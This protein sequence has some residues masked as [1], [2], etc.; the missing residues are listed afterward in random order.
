MEKCHPY[1]YSLDR[2]NVNDYDK[3]KILKLYECGVQRGLIHEDDCVEDQVID[4]GEIDI[5]NGS[6]C[7][8]P[9]DSLT[10]TTM[11]NTMTKPSVNNCYYNVLY[12]AVKD[13]CLK[14]GPFYSRATNEKDAINDCREFLSQNGY[15]DIEIM[16]VEHNAVE[17][18][19]TGNDSS[20]EFTDDKS[21]EMYE[22]DSV[23]F[24]KQ[25]TGDTSSSDAEQEMKKEDNPEKEVEKVADEFEK[26]E[27]P[28]EDAESE[29]K[30]EE[31]EETAEEKDDKKDDAE[32]KDEEK[33]EDKKEDKKEDEKKEDKNKE[34]S[35]EE[36]KED[37][38]AEEVKKYEE[39]KEDEK[40]LTGD[41]KAALKE[42]YNKIFKD[43]LGKM[44]LE[45]SIDDMTL[46]ERT[47]FY[48]KMSEKWTKNDPSEFMT[49][50]E[51]AELN[52]K[53]IKNK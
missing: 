25:E 50:K 21:F 12:S 40:K 3:E 42:E 51:Q 18:I 32:V 16:A 52:K 9:T 37:D 10:G 4:N 11:D 13:G 24:E 47:S 39:D 38:K 30:G 49:D 36:K 5:D 46:E 8:G 33:A 29:D 14:M 28:A 2:D 17:Q 45:K 1:I 31:K 35:D 43:V 34:N 26:D 20:E 15:E 23:E 6:L 48:E 41:E 22:D 53:V 27:K 19:E 44:G 7:G